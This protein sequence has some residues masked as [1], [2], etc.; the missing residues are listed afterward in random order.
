MKENPDVLVVDGEINT[1]HTIKPNKELKIGIENMN[2][3][4][5]GSIQL[6]HNFMG[7]FRKTRKLASNSYRKMKINQINKRRAKNKVAAKAR[8]INRLRAK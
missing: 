1:I 7:L 6:P 4:P 3:E 2:N 8:R 5:K